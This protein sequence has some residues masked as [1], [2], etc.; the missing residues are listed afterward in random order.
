MRMQI[1]TGTRAVEVTIAQLNLAH[2]CP[3]A[4]YYLRMGKMR[5]RWQDRW[6][7]RASG[8]PRPS[9]QRRVAERMRSEWLSPDSRA[10]AWTSKRQRAALLPVVGAS[11]QQLEQM[12]SVQRPLWGERK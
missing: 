7:G 3:P 9:G 10:R 12:G 5:L 1:Y 6:T 11:T 8:Q 4:M 2:S